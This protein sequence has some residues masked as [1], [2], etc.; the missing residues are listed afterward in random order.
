LERRERALLV[1]LKLPGTTDYQIEDLLD[2]LS[3]LVRTAGGEE[4]GRIIQERS[5]PTPGYFIGRGKAEE[6]RGFCQEAGIDLVVFD[7]DLT[8][9][10]QWHLEQIIQRKVIDR[11][12]L[13]LDIFAQRARTRE[14]K[15]QVEL[16]QLE[17]L[18]PR[19]RGKGL[20]LSRLG[21]GI[22][23]RGPGETQLE[24]DRRRIRQ[25]IAK[26]KKELEEVRRHRRLSRE[27][28]HSIPLPII[29]LVGYTNAGK[30]TLL[31]ALT[32]ASVL[33]EDKLFATLDPTTRRVVLPN[34]QVILLSDTVGFIRKLPH[35][36]VAAFKA[37]LEELASADILVHVVDAAHPDVEE[38]VAAV[39]QI[40]KELGLEHK[41]TITVLNKIDKLG[42]PH[43]LR[44]LE[45]IIGSDVSISALEG[46]HLDTLLARFAEHLQHMRTRFAF[47]LPYSSQQIISLIHNRGRILHAEYLPEEIL[48][49]AEVDFKTASLINSRLNSTAETESGCRTK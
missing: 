36:L 17:Y 25:R 41:P 42:N 39:K 33:V 4:V 5:Q 18:L 34:R 48:V 21:G 19:L 12:A 13:I 35:Q 45:R 40:L 2:E 6:I 38:Q 14:G 46:R 16:A 29:A 49:E 44:C 37:T 3:L 30:S 9:G 22:G 1:A 10:Q 47:R 24:V 11:T 31:N 23:T 32:R 43:L 20:I 28:R 8:P 7:D 27:R 15:L 26:I